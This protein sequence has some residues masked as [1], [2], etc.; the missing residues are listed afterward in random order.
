MC[1]FSSYGNNE[2]RVDVG[3]ARELGLVEVHDKQFVRGC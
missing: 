2:L 1:T 3:E